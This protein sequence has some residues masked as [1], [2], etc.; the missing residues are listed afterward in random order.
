MAFPS[1]STRRCEMRLFQ[2]LREMADTNFEEKQHPRRGDGEFAPKAGLKGAD[3]RHQRRAEDRHTKDDNKSP[4]TPAGL[5]PAPE[6]REEWPEHIKRL[7]IPPAW[8]HVHISDDPESNLQAFGRDAKGRSQYV[9]SAKFQE[10]QAAL[11]FARIKELD[12]KF[13]SIKRQ[14]A[15]DRKHDNPRIKDAAD[16]TYL[17]MT[18]GVRPGSEAETGA[19]VKAYGASTLEGRHVTTIDGVLHLHFIGKKGIELKLPVRDKSVAEMLKKRADEAGESG[20]LF[21]HVSEKALLEYVHGLDGGGFKTKDMRTRLGTKLAQ[22]LVDKMP[23]PKNPTEYRKSVREVAK[24]VAA[25]LGNTPAVALSA[26]IS[27]VVWGSWSDAMSKEETA[28]RFNGKRPLPDAHFGTIGNKP[29]WRKRPDKDRDDDTPRQLPKSVRML[30]GFNP[31][32]RD[33]R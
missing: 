20:Q 26:Y 31:F 18:M 1:H 6:S 21:P 8:T 24:R 4:S 16:C 14:N 27:P 19:D 11:K 25:K 33:K 17:I 32:K 9:Y 23:A 30:I 3:N 22:T 5:S 29:D 7:R 13:D 2:R 28:S 10:S 15:R 12:D